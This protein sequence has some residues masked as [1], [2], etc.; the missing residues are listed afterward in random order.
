MGLLLISGVQLFGRVSVP[1]PGI[2]LSPTSF[3]GPFPRYN[4]LAY[5]LSHLR[6]LFFPA[7]GK[8]GS[9]ERFQFLLP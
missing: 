4:I 7:L 6:L 5:F 2:E 3:S 1:P 9:L 8:T